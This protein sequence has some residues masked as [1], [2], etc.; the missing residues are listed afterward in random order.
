MRRA[1]RLLSCQIMGSF[2]FFFTLRPALDINVTCFS[3]INSQ[4]GDPR[5]KTREAHFC[6][7]GCADA[8]G[9]LGNG[10]RFCFFFN[11]SDDE[12][13]LNS[14]GPSEPLGLLALISGRSLLQRDE[15]K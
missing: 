11:Y 1:L 8:P 2:F 10:V 3:R 6:T 7:E 13:A 12:M 14:Q 4:V 15:A 5:D 9:P